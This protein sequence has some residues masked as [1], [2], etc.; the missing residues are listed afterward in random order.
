MASSLRKIQRPESVQTPAIFKKHFSGVFP[1]EKNWFDTKTRDVF[2]AIR[3][4]SSR[5]NMSSKK[6]VHQLLAPRLTDPFKPAPSE[7]E[8][9]N[10]DSD[11]EMN[12]VISDAMTPRR[13]MDPTDVYHPR[14]HPESRCR[15]NT[16]LFNRVTQ[17]TWVGNISLLSKEHSV[18]QVGILHSQQ[19]STSSTSNFQPT[20]NCFASEPRPDIGQLRHTQHCFTYTS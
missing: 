19:L 9:R 11:S 12:V 17:L 1:V 7:L 18:Q 13:G 6:L 10:R 15:K 16:H 14:Q 8:I 2:C 5:E 3:A 20:F 4:P